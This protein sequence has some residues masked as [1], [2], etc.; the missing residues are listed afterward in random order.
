MKLEII[1]FNDCVK[2]YDLDLSKDY[3]LIPFTDWFIMDFGAM[4]VFD[5]W[6]DGSELN[7]AYCVIVDWDDWKEFSKR[8]LTLTEL[9]KQNGYYF[10]NGE[11]L[12]KEEQKGVN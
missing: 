7:E 2:K 11:I 10:E 6:I 3:V 9:I 5:D 8:K 12:K 1:K 4:G